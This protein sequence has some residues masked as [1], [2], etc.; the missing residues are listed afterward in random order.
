MTIRPREQ[1][2]VQATALRF[3][4]T[5]DNWILDHIDLTVERGDRVALVGPSGSGKS[6]IL[7]LVAGVLR[8]DSGQLTVVGRDMAEASNR[9]AIR[10]SAVAWVQQSSNLLPERTAS[11]NVALALRIRGHD[12]RDAQERAVVALTAVGLA[13]HAGVKTA[14]LSG[15]QAQRVCVARALACEP[16]VLLADEPTGQL[17]AGTSEQVG[18]ALLTASHQLGTT[19]LL[20]THDRNAAEACDIVLRVH[21]GRF[22]A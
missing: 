20:A 13:D 17:D 5:V 10:R 1:T 11:E 12:E 19:V 2:V 9:R 22:A 7:S 21:N 4:Y 6:T 14:R 3:A 18:D 8:A 15:G 16:E